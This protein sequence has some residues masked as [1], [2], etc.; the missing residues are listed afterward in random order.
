VP[1]DAPP[2]K[3]QLDEVLRVAENIK[4]RSAPTYLVQSVNPGGN[5]TLSIDSCDFYL[6]Q[7]MIEAGSPQD[8]IE[9]MM[10]EQLALVHHNIGRL[11][12]KAA[13]A[14][15]MLQEKILLA[16]VA[17]LVGEFRRGIL[18]LKKYREP[19]PPTYR[20]VVRQQNVAQ[21]QQVALIEGGEIP[22]PLNASKPQAPSI[23][24]PEKL[25]SKPHALAH[26]PQPGFFPKPQTGSG[27]P[28]EPAVAKRTDD[29]G[30]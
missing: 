6:Q 7:M 18:A 30:P 15:T 11:Y 19:T 5:P 10:I 25:G 12:V 9:R 3:E 29:R 23:Q 17:R 1:E 13:S 14:E 24:Q 26:N 4:L 20:T 21:N 8:P 27:R 28:E 22:A 2:S 16:A